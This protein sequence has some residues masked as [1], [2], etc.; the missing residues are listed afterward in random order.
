MAKVVLAYSGGLDTS[1]AIHWLREEKGLEVVTFS[2]DLGQ[3]E[4]LPPTKERALKNGAVEAYI[5]DL[6]DEFVKEFIFPAIKAE[7]FY[8]DGYLLATALGRPL[9]ARELVRYARETG[10]EFIS[11][12]CTGKGN[13]QVRIETT[14]AALAPDIS[15]IAPLRE[16]SMGSRQEEIEYAR[17]AG[18]DIGDVSEDK[19]YS[20][21]RNL[22][23]V[24]I[25]CGVLE[26]PWNAP[27]EEPYLVTA[28]P[29][30]AP[31]EPEEVV[32]NFREGLP[33]GLDGK[34][35]AG[36]ELIETLNERA[37]RHGVGRVDVVE[38]RLVGIK[39]REVYE[40]P[41]GEV[42]FAAHQA[43]AR[44]TLPK[45]LISE[46][47]TLS[48]RYGQLVYDGLWYT[49]LRR[50]L[51][52]FFEEANRVVTGDVR[53]RMHKGRAVVVGRRSPNALYVHSLS[54]YD[55]S[56]QFDHSAAIGFIKLWSLPVAVAERIERERAEMDK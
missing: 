10:A 54:T 55:P 48:Q 47:R 16:W 43:L 15:I 23:G 6:K 8:G 52:A 56:D 22:W 26:D 46:G 41:A 49:A 1:V 40:S 30:E 44:M 50:A 51:D 19:P 37:G 31:D 21:D 9:I 53:V 32:V 2:A 24:S 33:V 34:E 13:D 27:P 35:M 4:A 18:L 28:A 14:V 12:G 45:D 17:K 5:A 11:H 7:A 42:V 20:Y 3:G 29:S 36:V 38:D 25:E 39:S